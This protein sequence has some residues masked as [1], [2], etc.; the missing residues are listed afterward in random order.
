MLDPVHMYVP[1]HLMLKSEHICGVYVAVNTHGFVCVAT[2][3]IPNILA[4]IDRVLALKEIKPQEFNIMTQNWMHPQVPV[5]FQLPES[6]VVP[7][8]HMR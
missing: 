3:C 4:N 7:T 6:S 1:T 5:C 8:M 2:F